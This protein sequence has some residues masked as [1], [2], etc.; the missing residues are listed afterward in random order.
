MSRQLNLLVRRSPTR[1]LNARRALLLL[2]LQLALMGAI[3]GV[4]GT[5]SWLQAREAAAGAA[6]MAAL[7]RDLD[8]LAKKTQSQNAQ[9]AALAAELEALKLT[10]KSSEA[11]VQSLNKN[12]SLS[13]DG[14]APQMQMLARIAEQ[15]VWLTGVSITQ[16]GK[17]MTLDGRA[18][19][20]EAVLEYAQ[21]ANAQFAP[22]GVRFSS[23]ELTPPAPVKDSATT[24]VSEPVAFKLF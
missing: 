22:L 12:A 13:S 21:R 2:G 6:E 16:G 10:L 4:A 8:N 15:K 24:A 5:R 17:N 20:A 18:V 3:G 14:Y 19:T 7:K 11:M 23:L 1:L 9:A